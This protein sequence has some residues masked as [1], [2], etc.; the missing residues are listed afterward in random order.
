MN[1]TTGTE[2]KQK[3]LLPS[4]EASA[5]QFMGIQSVLLRLMKT[6]RIYSTAQDHNSM[7]LLLRFPDVVL[8]SAIHLMRQNMLYL[9]RKRGTQLSWSGIL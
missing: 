9:N 5:G 7:G 3:L 2:L 8:R 4:T 6:T 1:L